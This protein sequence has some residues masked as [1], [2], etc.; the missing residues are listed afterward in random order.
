MVRDI[1]VVIVLV[2]MGS[3]GVAPAEAGSIPIA[4]PSFEG[5]VVD[6]NGFPVLPYTERW[7][8]L[9]VDTLGSTNTGVFANTPEGSPDRVAN[10]DGSQLA[11][12]GSE[13]GNALEQDLAAV[14]RAGCD[15]RLTVAVGVSGLFPPAAEEPVDTLEL[16]LYYRDANEPVDIARRT[17]PAGGLSATLLKDFSVYLPPVNSGAAWAGKPIGVAIRAVGMPGGFWD[18]DNVRLEES[19]PVAVPI[20]NASFEAPAVDPNGFPVLPYMEAWTELDVDAPGS[21]NTGVFGNS[22]EGSPDRVLNADGR[23]LA[24][25][26]SQEGN[27][28]EQDLPAVYRAGCDY[29]LT[30]AVGIS[31]QFPPA[32]EEPAD[33]LELVL[34]YRD[35]NEPA[36]IVYQ[37]V[38]AAGLSST[39][40]RD[41]S[42]HLPTVD[43]NDPWAGKPVGVAIRAAGMPGG[44]WDLDN[45][46]LAESLPVAVP[47]ENAS[48]EGPAVDPNGFPA[49]P[50]VD[51]W[52]EIDSD[53]EGSTNTGVFA[54]TPTD[55]PDHV[56]NAD[57]RQLAFLGSAQG[58][59]LEQDL[60]ATYQVGCAYRLTAGVGISGR[61]PPSA[62]APVDSLELVLY[63]HEDGNSVDIERRTVAV[64]GR[65]MTHL[66]DFPVYLPPVRPDDAW[67]G[68]GIGIAI[69]AAG[70]PGGFWDLDHVRLGES[71][72]PADAEPV[73]EE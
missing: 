65:T 20:E 67:A 66:D 69:R 4:N 16:V 42:V 33:A 51:Q 45:V 55:S 38:D 34:Y 60:A 28:L 22:P 37:T 41:F 43:P 58:N 24:F 70:M 50:F 1:V 62:E 49:V 46:R 61:F 19:Q 39:Q 6:P 52:T 3:W 64:T 5:P 48:F 9:D 31:G 27:A 35:G 18:L 40:L 44:F 54:N 47:I 59:A 14:Y 2:A 71:L 73:V 72:P 25:L 21:T 17:V 26:G 32:S 13:Q 23:Q 15:Y 11:F 29:R 12:L 56:I 7:T 30:V 36:D 53:V 8:E 63:Y 68:K 10:A 57:G